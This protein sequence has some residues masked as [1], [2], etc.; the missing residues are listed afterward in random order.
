LLEIERSQGQGSGDD[1]NIWR[2]YIYIFD[3]TFFLSVP[4]E[5][6]NS[7]FRN[8]SLVVLFLFSNTIFP[9]HRFIFECTLEVIEVGDWSSLP[10]LF[11]WACIFVDPPQYQGEV[12]RK[13]WCIIL[14]C[15]LIEK[16]VCSI[17]TFCH[18]GS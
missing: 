14:E 11:V 5:E 2:L 6:D 4:I 16:Q 18:H 17:T 12:K 13:I 7:P 8:F 1:T 3:T 9:I 10:I 15:L